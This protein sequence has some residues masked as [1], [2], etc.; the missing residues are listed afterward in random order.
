MTSSKIVLPT[1][2][3]GASAASVGG[4]MYASSGKSKEITILDKV[5][6][7]LKKNHRIL[8]SKDDVAWQKFKE[9]YKAATG[10]G[11]SGVSEEQISN[12]CEVTLKEE[13]D[14][15]KYDKAEEWCVVYD[16]SLKESIGKSLLPA[17]GADE[18]WKKAWDKFSSGND[19]SEDLK[20]SDEALIGNSKPSDSEKGGS[21]L[22]TWCTSKYEMKMYELGAL[23]LAK[24]VEKWCNEEAG[25]G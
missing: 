25:N 6:E 9:V 2:A 23:D 21:A 14:Q 4:Y 3:A 1:L 17:S 12:W 8:T 13:F 7:S 16:L 18:K 11:I 15:E 22:N 19:S 20:L 5:K 24:K 10:K